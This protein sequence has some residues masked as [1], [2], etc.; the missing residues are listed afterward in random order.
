MSAKCKCGHSRENHSVRGGF[1]FCEGTT[2]KAC[3]CKGYESEPSAGMIA[4]HTPA[5]WKI[6]SDV[7]YTDGR[8]VFHGHWKENVTICRLRHEDKDTQ[9][10]N[11][12]LIAAAPELLEAAKEIVELAYLSDRGGIVEFRP[13]EFDDLKAAIARAEGGQS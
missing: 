7:P 3:D 6:R 10:A 1:P 2:M 11:A 13:H 8:V 12:H 9:Q 5:P 4:K